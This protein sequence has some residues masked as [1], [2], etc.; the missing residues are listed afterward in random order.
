MHILLFISIAFFTIYLIGVTFYKGVPDSI[1]D[2]YYLLGEGKPISS[3][4]TIFCWVVGG[5]LLPYWIDYSSTDFDLLPFIACSSLIFVG[6]APLFKSYQKR[7]H[8]VSAIVCLISAY[9][10]AILY[11]SHVIASFGVFASFFVNIVSKKKVFWIEVIAF[12]M[13]YSS[14]IVT[15]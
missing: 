1:S 12:M 8:L 13:I 10:W 2:S 4:F 6:S 14:L 9:L 15:E 11:G 7:I 5:F 3:L